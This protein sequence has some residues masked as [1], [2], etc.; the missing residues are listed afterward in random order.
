MKGCVEDARVKPVSRV[1]VCMRIT[2]VL[3]GFL[4]VSTF[5]LAPAQAGAKA[6]RRC[7]P[8]GS[9]VILAGRQAQLY[10]A[11]GRSGLAEIF[12]CLRA[13]GRRRTLGPVS[14]F[15]S[16]GGV[17]TDRETL[18]GTTVAFQAIGSFSIGE[19]LASSH[20]VLVISLRSGR[21]LHSVPSGPSREA[22]SES[23][24]SGPVRSLVVTPAGE[25]A[26]IVEAL[27]GPL[28]PSF[29]VRAL[30]GS[31]SRLLA[32]GGDVDP[33]SLRLAGGRLSWAQG[34]LAASVPFG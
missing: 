29:E 10:R 13:G 3:A 4:A 16:Q 8:R 19:S 33:R 31:G 1:S 17:G 22:A 12:G 20:R 34:G 14:S 21:T 2:T 7:A 27:A 28:P 6:L 26:W 9:T 11:F 25:A 15:S 18:A 24:G 32:A 5:A 23:V 30:E